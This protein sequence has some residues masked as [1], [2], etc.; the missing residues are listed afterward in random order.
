MLHFVSYF[1]ND[2]EKLDSIDLL[3]FLKPGEVIE[4]KALTKIT[5]E[6]EIVFECDN[7]EDSLQQ[8]TEFYNDI[9]QNIKKSMKTSDLNFEEKTL[10]CI[11]F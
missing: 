11:M 6:K 1:E 7:V 3:K 9:Q 8:H 2:I 4:P 5:A 10:I